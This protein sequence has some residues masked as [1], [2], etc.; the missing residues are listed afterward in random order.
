M[1]SKTSITYYIIINGGLILMSYTE[2]MIIKYFDYAFVVCFIANMLQM[3]IFTYILN[4]LS[5]KREY[6]TPGERKNNFDIINYYKTILVNTISYYIINKYISIPS[7]NII[8]NIIYFIPKSFIYELVF[9]LGHYSTHRILHTYPILYRYIHKK[10]H[11]DNLINIYT[12]YNHTTLD[13]LITNTVPLII[14]SC[15][16]PMSQF[17]QILMKSYKSVTELAGHTGKKNN[18]SSFIQ[19]IWLVR[20]LRIELKNEDHNNH[21]GSSACNYSKRFSI[22]DKV[23]NT[24]KRS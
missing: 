19:C 21:H 4:I 1:I 11:E 3:S 6:Y 13:Y 18:S 2:Y 17:E 15:I 22:W 24:Y 23:F 8:Q 20:L 12:T 7:S 10:H 14:T 16:V 5:E 9:D